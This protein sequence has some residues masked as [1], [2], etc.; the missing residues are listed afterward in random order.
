MQWLRY[1]EHQAS[2]TVQHLTMFPA[3]TLQL[4]LGK[5][6][7]VAL[8]LHSVSHLHEGSKVC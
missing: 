2:I 5:P 4:L 6:Q 3:V 7:P 8:V 1:D